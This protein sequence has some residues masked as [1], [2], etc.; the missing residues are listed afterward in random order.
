MINERE[1]VN[2]RMIHS[3]AHCPSKFSDGSGLLSAVSAR[4][5]VAAHDETLENLWWRKKEKKE[6]GTREKKR[7]G[8]LVPGVGQ[9]RYSLYTN[10]GNGGPRFSPRPTTMELWTR[11]DFCLPRP[12][13]FTFHASSRLP[14]ISKCWTVFT[15]SHQRRRLFF[16]SR[17]GGR[18]RN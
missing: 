4:I 1:L 18:K 8:R 3:R 10:L 2:E 9:W 6:E 14:K 13:Q 12:I 7:E 15:I 16:S 5:V 11:A 17:F